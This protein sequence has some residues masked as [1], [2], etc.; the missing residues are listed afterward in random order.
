M[1]DDILKNLTA[2][3]PR[4]LTTQA[5]II[6]RGLQEIS[7]HLAEDTVQQAFKLFQ[8]RQ[9]EEAIAICTH[10]IEVASNNE[11]TWQAHSLWQ[12]H[13]V[14]LGEQGNYTEALISIDRALDLDSENPYCWSIKSS[15]L[16]K[17]GHYSD[18]IACDERAINLDP[19]NSRFRENRKSHFAKLKKMGTRRILVVNDEESFCQSICELLAQAGYECRPVSGGPEALAILGSE[20]SFDL[21]IHDLLNPHLDGFSLLRQAKQ[22]FPELPIIIA[23]AIDDKSL[24]DA[25]MQNGA[26]AYLRVP[27]DVEELFATVSRVFKGGKKSD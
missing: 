12:I 2:Q 11:I 20:N 21:L 18:A 13:G 26:Y 25:C 23:S 14:C 10:G 27:L 17:S 1:A 9:L 6:T 4:H 22:Q 7:N 5:S 24:V 15:L 16:A 3:M 8:E 19:E